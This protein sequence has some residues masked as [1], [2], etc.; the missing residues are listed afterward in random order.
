MD[1]VFDVSACYLIASYVLPNYFIAH[2][3]VKLIKFLYLNVRIV[4]FF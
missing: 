3:N 2:G 4:K 1:S